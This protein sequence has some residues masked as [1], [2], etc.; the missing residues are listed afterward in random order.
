[1]APAAYCACWPT[2]MP[3]G[4]G[5]LESQ[6]ISVAQIGLVFVLGKTLP[7]F[8]ATFSGP[9]SFPMSG[10]TTSSGLIAWRPGGPIGYGWWARMLNFAGV[11]LQLRAFS[12]D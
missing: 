11:A 1:M 7:A 8:S 9:L 5:G 4:S 3:P 2:G 6:D 10:T 12:F